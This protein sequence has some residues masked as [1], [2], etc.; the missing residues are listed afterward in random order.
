[1]KILI[2]AIALVVAA[3]FFLQHRATV[4]AEKEAPPIGQFVEVEGERLH[5]VDIPAADGGAAPPVLLIHGASVNLRDMKIA[6][7]PALAAHHRVIV[8][9]RPGRGYSTR[10]ADGWKLGVQARLI[11]GALKKLGVEN[12]VVVGQSLGSA[13]ALA[14]TLQYQEEMTGLVLL[15]P[16]SHRWPG[17]VA[18]Y[19]KVSGWP[20]AGFLLRRLL[21][22]FY[23]PYAAKSGVPASFGPGKAPETYVKESGLNLVFRP[24]DFEANAADIRH[25][26]EEVVAMG[27]RYGEIRIPTAILMGLSDKTVSREIHAEALAREIPGVSYETLP[28][29][30]HALHHSQTTRVVAAIEIVAGGSKE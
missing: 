23:G 8:I 1:M 18:W 15:A 9:D 14:Y 28:D 26:K 11:H 5:V 30:G 10:P 16:V 24:R 20:V 22:P 4:Q 21:I 29:T 13:V 19:N 17:G 27:G 7:G 25:L 12:P 2:G 6:L 3:L